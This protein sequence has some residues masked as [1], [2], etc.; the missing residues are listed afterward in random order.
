MMKFTLPRYR[1]SAADPSGDYVNMD[2]SAEGLVIPERYGTILNLKPVCMNLLTGRWKLNRRGMHAITE[3]REAGI[4][5]DPATEYSTDLLLGEFTIGTTPALIGGTPYYFVLESDY[6]ENGVDYLGIGQQTDGALYLDGTCYFINAADVWTDT[7]CDIQFR[8]YVKDTMDGPE[9]VLIDNWI[10]SPGWNYQAYLRKAVAG[11]QRRLAQSFLTPAGGPWFLS[12]IQVEAYEYG[13][14]DPARTTKT[15]LLSSY[16]PDVQV[17]TKSYRMENYSGIA[18]WSYFPQRAAAADLTVDIEGIEDG[19]GNLMTQ[20]ADVVADI[21]VNILGG[22]LAKLN[23]QDLLDLAAAR[24]QILALNIESEI[25]MESLMKTFEAG[26]LWKFIPLTD[27]TFGLKFAATGEPPGTPHY[28]DPHLKNFRMTRSWESIFQRVKIKY[29][30]DGGD[31]LWL[32]VE[33]ESEIARYFYKNQ[34]LLEI[35][36][37]LTD[38]A[39]AVLLAKDYLGTTGSGGRR[40]YLQTPKILAE[41]DL[42]G[43]QG[44]DRLPMNKVKITRARGMSATGA[45]TGVLFRVL[46]V[47]KKQ[48]D[49]SVHIGAILD[50]QTY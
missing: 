26:Q 38:Q 37:Y 14:P 4:I 40:Q 18:D 27:G 6:V 5:L 8:I 29:A 23:A 32:A 9:F 12:R 19:G 42:K 15:T 21:Y 24:T 34:K 28:F 36:T 46:S 7:F 39:D 22:T 44:W 13:A 10:W 45:L 17:G 48:A 20:L 47:S 2:P 25:D 43:G 49:G 31:N 1:F 11:D 35:E 3:I 33:E 16:N 50:S 41:F 30:K